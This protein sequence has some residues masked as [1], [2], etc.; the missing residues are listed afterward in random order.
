[1]RKLTDRAF[2][3]CLLAVLLAVPAWV[4]LRSHR[5]TAAYY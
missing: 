3:A 1:M 5:E 2:L 4:A